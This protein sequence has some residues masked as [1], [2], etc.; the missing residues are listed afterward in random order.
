MNASPRVGGT[1]REMS[2][3]GVVFCHRYRS[4]S[5]SQNQ[6]LQSYLYVKLADKVSWVPSSND[7]VSALP[8]HCRLRLQADERALA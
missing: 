3:H 8:T 7:A 2:E 1:L 4:C 6:R 5:S